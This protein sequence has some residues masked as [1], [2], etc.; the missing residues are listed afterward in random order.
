MILSDR[1]FPEEI[2][3]HRLAFRKANIRSNPYEG[4]N[5]LRRTPC[6]KGRQ[7]G[8]KRKSEQGEVRDI[9]SF[10]N[11]I[12]HLP[13]IEH[14]PLQGH[15]PERHIRTGGFAASPQ[16]PVDNPVRV[17]PSQAL[18]Q[19]IRL[20]NDRKTRSGLYKQKDRKV[21]PFAS[22]ENPLG[23]VTDRHAFQETD[24]SCSIPESPHE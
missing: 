19:G 13:D 4:M 14:E 16:V 24:G 8:A 18:L 7:A 22:H 6:R 12:D 1:C 9:Q 20:V 5:S 21:A 15:F 23:V 10:E 11:V 2:P 3:G 17:F